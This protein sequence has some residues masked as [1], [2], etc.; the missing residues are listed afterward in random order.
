[1]IESKTGSADTSPTTEVV[2]RIREF[3]RDYV[4]LVGAYDYAHRLGTPHSLP[5]ARVIWELA[6]REHTRVTDLRR[7]VD[8]DAGQLSRLLTQAEATGLVER[9]RDPA[10]SRR[11]LIRLT[12]A[13][14]DAV[15]LLDTRSNSVIGEQIHR[16]TTAE[17]ERLLAAL[18]TVA[19]LLGLDHGRPA[20]PG[21][22]L[23]PP[24][25]GEFGWVVQRHAVRYAEGYGWH[26]GFE[27]LVARAV[28][29]FAAEHDP[30]RESCWIAEHAGE[31]VGSVFCVD[32]GDTVAGLPAARLRLLLVEPAARG[33]G[34]G[35]ALVAEAVRFARE[36]GHHGMVLW[37]ND[38][39]T[40]ARRIYRAAGFTLVATTPHTRFGPPANGEDWELR[41]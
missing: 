25:T 13:G 36:A 16:L 15:A 34:I 10:D 9:Q 17:R 38:V 18:D 12:P 21:F 24:R 35:G 20:E 14:R 3:N 26:T 19:R 6:G 29:R 5:E 4:K 11:Q 23:R 41:F 33:L 30:A 22:L 39:L 37:T 28:G 2:R 27:A 7:A 1:M 31:P 32:E 40:S 8:M